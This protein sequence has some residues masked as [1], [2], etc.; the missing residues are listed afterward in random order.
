MLFK[1]LA[2]TVVLLSTAS[3]AESPTRFNGNYT[4]KCADSTL[5]LSVLLGGGNNAG[6]DAS[7]GSNTVPIYCGPSPPSASDPAAVQNLWTEYQQRLN[8]A[9]QEFGAGCN[10]L[11][12]N[13][14]LPPRQ[15]QCSDAAAEWRRGIVEL[16]NKMAGLAPEALR[17]IVQPG[18]NGNYLLNLYNT[19]TRLTLADGTDLPLTYTINRSGQLFSVS[20]NGA[21]NIVTSDA[22]CVGVVAVVSQGDLNLDGTSKLV[23]DYGG[24]LTCGVAAGNLR[25]GVAATAAVHAATI[26]TS[27]VPSTTTPAP[28]VAPPA[29]A[30]VQYVGGPKCFSSHTRVQ[31]EGKA[32]WTMM[33]DLQVGDSVVAEHGHYSKVYS[34]GHKDPLA[35]TKYLQILTESMDKRHPLEISA[36]HLIY[37]QDAAGRTSMSP[38]SDLKAGSTLA[39]DR[40]D[41]S[42]V[43]SIR[44]V[45]RQGAY[46]PLTESGNLII[47]GVLASNYV[48][49]GWIPKSCGVS[50]D[51][52]HFLQ[53]GASLPHRLLCN[54]LDCRG[55]PYNERTGLSPWV[56]FWF[57]IEQW[58]LQLSSFLQIVFLVTFVAL[59]AIALIALGKL[60]SIAQITAA[61]YVAVSVVGMGVH[62]CWHHRSGRHTINSKFMQNQ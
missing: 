59:P 61:R 6:T 40:G 29:P 3:Q 18:D 23:N 46:A 47:N 2:F 22:G 26:E 12:S 39:S 15:Q 35:T 57:D 49:R 44:I 37:T 58:L 45:E 32:G 48:S 25:I 4:F 10:T 17:I 54:A 9:E 8:T 36:E 42:T 56:Q 1:S 27:R 13:L 7:G 14:G 51:A 19:Y 60:A 24:L 52:L 55:E 34:F 31:V 50:A 43:L 41:P 21:R 5:T 11:V 33:E 38:A 53:H 30:P 20:L 62:H 16:N 28:V